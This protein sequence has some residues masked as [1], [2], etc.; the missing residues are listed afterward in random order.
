MLTPDKDMTR[1]IS[2]G[3]PDP[4]PAPSGHPLP[5][6]EGQPARL[7]FSPGR[8]WP[9]GPDEG[10]DRPFLIP[11]RLPHDVHMLVANL[12]VRDIRQKFAE[13]SSS[14]CLRLV[15]NP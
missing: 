10:S 6:G 5:R 14:L 11:G 7:S 2:D 13:G 1:G 12:I 15:A 4:S 9:E 3:L 8:R